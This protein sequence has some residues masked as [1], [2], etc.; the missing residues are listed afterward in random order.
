[1]TPDRAT[2][3]ERLSPEQ[4]ARVD[5]ACD[6]FET[7]WKAVGHNGQGPDLRAALA[8]FQDPER[9]ALALE[10]IALDQAYRHKQGTFLQQ[11]DYRGLCAD[12]DRRAAR[13]GAHGA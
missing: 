5:R 9:T 13:P 3:Y 10:L 1:M 6:V 7:D 8:A 12:Y 11:T 4:A 2:P